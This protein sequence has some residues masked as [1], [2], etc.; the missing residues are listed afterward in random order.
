M[1]VLETAVRGIKEET[2]VVPQAGLPVALL[3]EPMWL[4]LL[5]SRGLF[6]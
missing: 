6:V 3:R 1:A 2:S 5:L 4:W